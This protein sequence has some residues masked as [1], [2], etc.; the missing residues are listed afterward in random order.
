MNFNTV[1][2]K[3]KVFLIWSQKYTKTD[4]VYLAKGSFWLS[5][6]H[7]IIIGASFLQ[8][9]FLTNFL[10]PEI[11]GNYKYLIS[12]AGGLG[13]FLLSG[14]NNAITQAVAKKKE[15]TYQKSI[16]IQLQWGIIFTLISFAAATFYYLQNNLTFALSLLIIGILNPLINSFNTFIAFLNGRGEFKKIANYSFLVN[17]FPA[18]ITVISIF[19][20]NLI[21]IILAYYLS[22]TLINIYYYFKCKKEVKNDEIDNSLLKYGKHLSLIN[23]FII[24]FFYLDK[25]FIF[26]FLGPISLAIYYL[27]Q[28]IPEQIKSGLK[29]LNVI[30]LPKL[31]QNAKIDKK[32]FNSLLSK[33]FKLSA[34]VL[35]LVIIYII[36]CPYIFKIFFP[37]YLI[38]IQL[39]KIFAISI[40]FVAFNNTLIN[41]LQS[42]KITKKLYIYTITTSLIQITSIIASIIFFGLIG[43]AVAKII[44][45]AINSFILIFISKKLITSQQL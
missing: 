30:S 15:G 12:F 9:W 14:M 24:I 7:I 10:S 25:L 16:V 28:A 42:L 19:S 2:E 44:T 41:Y 23:F 21:I 27:A 5:Y 38:A 37:K 4:M 18:V 36:I 35:L 43:G 17:L 8:T 13:A 20:K 40:I 33:I 31:T 26:H 39:S 34:V 11:Y 3:I 22:N 32:Y 6:R 1:K 45:E 29:I